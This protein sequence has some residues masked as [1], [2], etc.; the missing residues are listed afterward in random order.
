M[1]AVRRGRVYTIPFHIKEV[2]L[3]FCKSSQRIIRTPIWSI[4]DGDSVLVLHGLSIM[5]NVNH[6]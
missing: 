4:R 3:E 5:I 2:H 1:Y 6:T